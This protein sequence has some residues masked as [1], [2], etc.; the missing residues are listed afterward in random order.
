[1]DGAGGGEGVSGVG[2][3]VTRPFGFKNK[4]HKLKS[5]TILLTGSGHLQALKWFR[6]RGV[7]G[8]ETQE[9]DRAHDSGDRQARLRGCGRK[10][11]RGRNQVGLGGAILAGHTEKWGDREGGE[12]GRGGACPVL[13]AILTVA[14][15]GT[16]HCGLGGGGRDLY[17]SLCHGPWPRYQC[18]EGG[19][20]GA[21]VR[22]SRVA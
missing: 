5:C 3:G 15:P 17:S 11:R 2:E 18:E 14:R 19:R 22:L 16:G 1:M 8:S 7:S 10:V 12:G 21:R 4:I 13:R 20:V 6:N 9:G